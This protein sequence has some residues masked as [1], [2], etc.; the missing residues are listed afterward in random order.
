M[1]LKE[2]LVQEE[3]PLVAMRL[4]ISMNFLNESL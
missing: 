3:I 4:K 1:G 2:N